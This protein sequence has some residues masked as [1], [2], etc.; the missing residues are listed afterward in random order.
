MHGIVLGLVLTVLAAYYLAMIWA[1][2]VIAATEP[3]Q[4]PL[5]QAD[6]PDMEAPQP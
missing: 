1:G 5:P 2:L 6:A 3:A 4:A